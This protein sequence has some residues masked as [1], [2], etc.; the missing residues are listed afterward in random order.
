MK[1]EAELLKRLHQLLAE[2]GEK[3]GEVVEPITMETCDPDLEIYPVGKSGVIAL[4]GGYLLAAWPEEERHMAT[5]PAY[6]QIHKWL[7]E[8]GEIKHMVHLHNV[9]S[10]ITT[11][12]LGARF[13][14]YDQQDY[15]HYVTTLDAFCHRNIGNVHKVASK[16][17]LSVGDRTT[18]GQEVASSEAA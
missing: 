16:P 15:A 3:Y 11:R 1:S 7:R 17:Q 4:I 13:V 9:I 8:R 5:R 12:R 14:G 18:H 2:A 10:I 6:R